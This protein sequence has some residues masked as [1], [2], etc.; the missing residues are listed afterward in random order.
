VTLICPYWMG[1]FTTNA[2]PRWASSTQGCRVLY[3]SS[4]FLSSAKQ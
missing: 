4:I 1:I 3:G 2:S